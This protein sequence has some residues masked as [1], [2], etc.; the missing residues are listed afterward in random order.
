V[1][2]GP[3]PLPAPE[4]ADGTTVPQPGFPD[5]TGDANAPQAILVLRVPPAAV[6]SVLASLSGTG[7]VTYRNRASADVTGQVADVNS[8][9][10]SAQAGITELRG[11]INRATDLGDLVSLENALEQRESDLESLEAEQRALGDETRLATVTV[12]FFG[13]G[14]PV[15]A[16]AGHT[17][18]T[19]GLLTGW[20]GFVDVVIAILV[21]LGWLLPFLAAMVAAAAILWLP[22]R[23]LRRRRQTPTAE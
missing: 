10:A 13:R 2:N 4:T 16:A 23:R 3:Q 9:V 21:A 14:T 20:H 5:V 12:E 18:F 1:G 7:T 22:V 11:L 6:D 19:K 17:G 8:R 15:V